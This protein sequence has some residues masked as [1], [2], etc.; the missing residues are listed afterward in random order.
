MPLLVML[1]SLA[2]CSRRD[3]ANVARIVAARRERPAIVLQ[4]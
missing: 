4:R 1:S 2:N 3:G